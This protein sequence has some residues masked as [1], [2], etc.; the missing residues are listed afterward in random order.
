[1]Y[2]NVSWTTLKDCVLTSSG[3]EPLSVSLDKPSIVLYSFFFFLA[4]SHHC[5]LELS[6]GPWTTLRT[7]SQDISL[8]V[9][10]ELWPRPPSNTFGINWLTSVSDLM[11]SVVAEWDYNKKSDVC[12]SCRLMPKLKKIYSTMKSRCDLRCPNTCGHIVHLHLFLL[13]GNK[14]P[15]PVVV[16]TSVVSAVPL[17]CLTSHAGRSWS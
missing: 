14:L 6:F 3:L 4:K 5:K 2:T 12:F 11:T 7:K 9:V 17:S 13:I 15:C 16:W 1:M 10:S 8:P